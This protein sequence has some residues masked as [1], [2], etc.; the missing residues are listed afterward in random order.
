MERERHIDDLKKIASLSK[1]KK[2][3]K[4]PKT[5]KPF[6]KKCNKGY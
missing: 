3:Y 1:N 4:N 5:K 2:K 6:G